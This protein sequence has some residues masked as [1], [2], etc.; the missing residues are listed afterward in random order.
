MEIFIEDC[1]IDF[2]GMDHYDYCSK[3]VI[4]FVIEGA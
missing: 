4:D 3:Q 2:L 1:P